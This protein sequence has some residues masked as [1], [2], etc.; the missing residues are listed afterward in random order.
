MG[1]KKISIDQLRAEVDDIIREYAD[2]VEA[3]TDKLSVQFA[4]IAKSELQSTSPKKTG[5][6]AKGWAYKKTSTKNKK[7]TT[8]H[9]KTDY[10]LTHLLEN[11]HAKRNGGRVPGIPH[12]APVEEEVCND[13]VNALERE[14]S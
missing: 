4:K 14:L 12:I 8:V 5:H 1:R 3:K 13:F 7:S 11:G 9:N 10:Q 6:Y 2:D